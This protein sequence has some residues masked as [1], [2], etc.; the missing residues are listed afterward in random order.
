[1]TVDIVGMQN[2]TAKFQEPGP[3][4]SQDLGK[5]EFLKLLMTQL[6]NQDPMS[7]Q[8]NEEFIAQLTSFANL[9]EVQNVGN[10]LED[11]LHMTAAS[12][13]AGTV[14]LLG[15]EVRVDSN[16]IDGPGKVFYELPQDAQSVEVKVHNA[17][18]DLEKTIKDVPYEEGVHEVNIEDLKEGSYTVSVEAEGVDGE[19]ID[20]SV[21]ILE[22]VDGVSFSENIPVLL[23]ESGEELPVSKVAEIRES[24]KF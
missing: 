5:Q 8:D 12:Q 7:P 1:M 20:A 22:K 21:S 23:L 3:A 16:E 17:A 18:G 6:Q 4:G 24:G 19:S 14:S 2:S 11:L 13:S 9:E 15:K 10:R